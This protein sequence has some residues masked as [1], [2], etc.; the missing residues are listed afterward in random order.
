MFHEDIY[1]RFC[2]RYT[3]INNYR[4]SLTCT[5]NFPESSHVIEVIFLIIKWGSD[6]LECLY[7]TLALIKEIVHLW[8]G[9]RLKR[10]ISICCGIRSVSLSLTCSTAHSNYLIYYNRIC[11]LFSQ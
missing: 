1:I 3:Y 10:D 9:S 5:T 8:T 6:I 7:H 4:E 11:C 2:E